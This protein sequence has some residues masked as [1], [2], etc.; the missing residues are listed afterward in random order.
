MCVFI[1]GSLHC[2]NLQISSDGKWNN[3]G[4]KQSQEILNPQS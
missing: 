3:E 4:D 1:I 2:Q